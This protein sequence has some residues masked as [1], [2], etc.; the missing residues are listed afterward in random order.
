MFVY[1]IEEVEEGMGVNP[2]TKGKNT[3]DVCKYIKKVKRTTEN[4]YVGKKG[5]ETWVSG[6]GRPRLRKPSERG[7]IGWWISKRG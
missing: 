7:E 6:K 4:S 1:N 3:A 5:G 2:L